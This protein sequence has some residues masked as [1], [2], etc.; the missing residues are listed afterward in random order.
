MIFRALALSILLALAPLSAA[1][2]T[3][4][5]ASPCRL[6]YRYDARDG[7]LTCGGSAGIYS[8]FAH[9]TARVNRRLPAGIELE[10]VYTYENDRPE[11]LRLYFRRNQ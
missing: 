6:M 8:F 5:Y 2:R 7:I 4:I 1:S 9:E 10:V 11:W 3:A